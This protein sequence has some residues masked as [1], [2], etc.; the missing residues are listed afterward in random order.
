MAAKYTQTLSRKDLPSFLRKLAD[1]CESQ[2]VEGLPDCTNAKKIRLS[3][4]DEYG[5]LAVKLKVSTVIDECELCE[6]YMYEDDKPSGLPPY[7]RLKKRMATSFK[8]IFKAL[9]QQTTPLKK[10]CGTLLLTHG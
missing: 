10:Q 1:A 5:E 6:D 3:I 8:V 4:K 7:K 2:P 9:H